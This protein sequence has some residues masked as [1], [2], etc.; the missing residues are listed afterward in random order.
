MHACGEVVPNEASLL[1]LVK[2]VLVEHQ[3]RMENP[4]AIP[5]ISK[6]TRNRLAEFTERPLLYPSLANKRLFVAM[7]MALRNPRAKEGD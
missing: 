7:L 1:R 2:V 4:I 6:L 5:H 3:R